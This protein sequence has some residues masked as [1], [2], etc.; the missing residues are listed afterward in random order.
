MLSSDDV[1]GVALNGVLMFSGTTHTG[2]DVFFPKSYGTKNEPVGYEF[3]VCLGTQVTLRTYRY[4]SYSPCVYPIALKTSA[5][6]CRDHAGCN[7]DVI[8]HALDNTPILA[9][10]L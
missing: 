9:R 7:K 4:H 8:K 10:G 2:Y 1:V 5:I 3:D 6:L